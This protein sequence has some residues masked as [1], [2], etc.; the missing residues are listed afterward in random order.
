MLCVGVGKGGQ[1]SFVPPCQLRVSLEFIR[2]FYFFI[3]TS[4]SVICE[5]PPCRSPAGSEQDPVP[6]ASV[7]RQASRLPGDTSLALNL[8]RARKRAREQF[9]KNLEQVSEVWGSAKVPVSKKQKKN[10]LCSFRSRLEPEAEV[11][12]D[13]WSF[14]LLWRSNKIN[15]FLIVWLKRKMCFESICL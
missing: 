7:W 6:E 12:S 15:T 9:S 10:L 4:P 1:L 2:L 14:S 8:N 13:C 3:S 5:K 11:T